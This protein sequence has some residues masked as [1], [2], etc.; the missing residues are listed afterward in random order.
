MIK[1]ALLGICSVLAFNPFLASAVTITKTG[2]IY[3]QSTASYDWSPDNVHWYFIGGTADTFCLNTCSG[4]PP[5]DVSPQMDPWGSTGYTSYIRTPNGGGTD[6]C[7]FL[8]SGSAGSWDYAEGTTISGT[9]TF[10]GDFI[11][12]PP[13]TGTTSAE[14]LQE[15]YDTNGTSTCSLLQEA[16]NIRLI[17]LILL[18]LALFYTIEH[19][20]YHI[21]NGKL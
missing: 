2:D 12:A 4:N 10:A 20:Y 15:C 11:T 5:W 19:Y 16:G 8:V 9:C 14:Y 21:F 18:V 7:S 17:L 6:K 1:Y 13:D 3:S